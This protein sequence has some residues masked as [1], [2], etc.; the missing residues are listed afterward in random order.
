VL[1][2]KHGTLVDL[3]DAHVL[4]YAPVMSSS[5][6]SAFYTV[7]QTVLRR[8]AAEISFGR[9]VRCNGAEFGSEDWAGGFA[10]SLSD[11]RRRRGRLLLI[12]LAPLAGLLQLGTAHVHPEKASPGTGLELSA[13]ES[14]ASA[15][16]VVSLNGDVPLRYAPDIQEKADA[17]WSYLVRKV[18]LAP[19][20]ASPYI[21]FHRFDK[22]TQSRKW[23]A[24]QTEWTRL[25]P[26]I[27]RDWTKLTRKG[28]EVEITDE[29]IRAN[30]QVIFPFPSTF[31][32]FH[33]D[34]TN[35]IQINPSRTFGASVQND[36]YG[37]MR[38]LSGQGY[39]SMG[40]EMLHY[41]LEAKGI[42][43]TRLHHCLFIH[44]VPGDAAKPIMEEVADYLVDQKMV[45]VTA[46]LTGLRSERYFDPCH[47]LTRAE[48][49]RVEMLAGELQYLD[50]S[51]VVSLGMPGTSGRTIWVR[52]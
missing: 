39:Y 48:L 4:I 33:Y 7:W 42:G 47:S 46:K 32:A 1:T 21:Y 45:S 25:H 43:P 19:G 14:G 12:A 17:I 44:A 38:D 6:T 3:E 16:S 28:T 5:S 26:G 27:W 2:G 23:T 15:R 10:P 35:R 49:S 13:A 24:W 18:R 30:I 34:G 50:R 11:G 31:L 8:L 41:A 40:H 29:W 37:V 22:A 52:R 36:P 51:R 9:P 20:T